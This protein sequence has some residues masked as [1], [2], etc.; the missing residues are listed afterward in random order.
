MQSG[1]PHAAGLLLL[2]AGAL[3]IALLLALVLAAR[4]VLPLTLALLLLTALVRLI[5]HGILLAFCVHRR[6]CRCV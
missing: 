1:A 6:D 3:R 4:L 2:L 5:R